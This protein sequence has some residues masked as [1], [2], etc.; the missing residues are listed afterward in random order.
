MPVQLPLIPS[1]PNYRTGVTLDGE[2]FILDMRWNTRDDAWYMDLYEG[3]ETPIRLGMKVVLGALI[4]IRSIN[5]NQPKGVMMASDL[6]GVGA[7]ATLDDLGV[8]VHVYFFTD[9]EVGL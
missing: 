8:R 6:S 7:D 3:D 2:Q 1:E 4:G 5:P 9:T